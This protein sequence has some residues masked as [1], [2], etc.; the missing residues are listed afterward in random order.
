MSG[1][2]L[3]KV[4]TAEIAPIEELKGWAELAVK[5]QI[6]PSN[7]NAFQAM[8][9]VQA[10]KEMG[11]Q[12][13]Q[14]LR[15]MSFIK[16]RLTM[17]V[18]LQLAMAKNRGVTMDDPEEGDG[19]CQV[20]LHRGKESVTCN[21]T[22][23]DAKKAGLIASGGNW[24]KYERQMLRWRAIGDALR[25][26]APDMTMNLLSPEEAASIDPL[27]PLPV[28]S[29]KELSP[30]PTTA[31]H[32]QIKG[33]PVPGN[34]PGTAG[35]GGKEPEKKDLQTM[36]NELQQLAEIAV[37]AGLYPKD[38]DAIYAWT[39]YVNKKTGKEAGFY[40]VA[41]L[42]FDWQATA[43]IDKANAQLN[44]KQ[45]FPTPDPDDNQDIDV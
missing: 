31:T 12:P 32:G 18:Q 3:A 13:L 19:F 37:D 1:Q 8:V 27:A 41:S 20:T 15:S 40:N 10:G 42:K 36:M 14:S 16:G 38:G 11:L 44:A 24:D 5:A 34:P 45:P 30:P 9:I 2:A 26:I 33:G 17:S 28:E 7:M 22:R 23:E 6:I 4:V 21:Y 29:L 39:K 25:L 35:L 43:A